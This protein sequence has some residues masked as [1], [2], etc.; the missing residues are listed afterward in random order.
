LLRKQGISD[1]RELRLRLDRDERALR[2]L[3]NRP[4]GYSVIVADPACLDFIDERPLGRPRSV[5]LCSDGFYRTVDHYGLRDD[6][7]LMMEAARG[8]LPGLYAEMRR[9]EAEDAACLRFPR[10]KASDDAATIVLL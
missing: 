7:S 9:I 6:R 3:R 1:P 2:A 4:G 10:L 5:L 8:N